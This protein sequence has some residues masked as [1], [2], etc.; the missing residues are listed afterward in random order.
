M[1]NN[2]RPRRLLCGGFD[3]EIRRQGV[4][5]AWQHGFVML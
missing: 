3:E 2:G 1:K 4:D 5:A